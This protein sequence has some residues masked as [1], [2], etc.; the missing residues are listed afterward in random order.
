[1][2]KKGTQKRREKILVQKISSIQMWAKKMIQTK[3]ID[4]IFI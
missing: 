1:M 2:R 4:Y 3:C